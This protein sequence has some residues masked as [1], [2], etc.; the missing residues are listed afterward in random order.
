MNVGIEPVFFDRD[1]FDGVRA[2]ILRQRRFHLRDAKHH[3]PSTGDRDPHRVWKTRD[4]HA[5]D[6]ITRSGI[7]EF[8]VI[9]DLQLRKPHRGD[10]L[11]RFECGLE[12]AGK[13][14]VGRDFALGRMHGGIESDKR[15]RV[16]GR[17]IV[18]RD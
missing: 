10:D 4:K 14:I 11:R 18:V 15:G 6:R 16:I 7:A 1:V 9:G 13:E 17:R 5:D 3:R 2:E 12:H 8:L